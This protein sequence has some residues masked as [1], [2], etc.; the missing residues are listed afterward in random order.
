[1]IAHISTEN[2]PGGK[3]KWH[4]MRNQRKHHQH[5]SSQ[6]RILKGTED[7]FI[8]LMYLNIVLII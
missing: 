5:G 7:T 4:R 3:S 1:V 2:L 6:F 8:E